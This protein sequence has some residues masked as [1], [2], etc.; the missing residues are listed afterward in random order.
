[1]DIFVPGRICLFGEH[2]DWAG[3][4]RRLNSAIARGVCL[5]TGTNQGLYAEVAPHPTHLVV[6]ADLGGPERVG[7]RELPME[8]VALRAEAEGGGPFAY[9]AGVAYQLLTHYRVGGLVLDNTRTDLPVKKG[10]ASSAAACVLAARAFNRVYNLKLTVRGE[11]EAAYRGELMTPSRCGRMDQGC[12]YGRRPVR[13]T[14][15]ADLVEVSPVSVGGDISMLIV[16]LQA[17]KDTLRILH[18]LNR[19]YPFA[20]GDRERHVHEYLGDINRRLVDRAAAAI[21]AGD[22]PAVGRLM[23]EAQALFDRY[24]TPLCPEELEAPKLH[25]VLDYGPIQELI[26]GG[27]GVGS[28]GDGAAQLVARSPKAR[29]EAAQILERDLGVRCLPLDLARPNRIRKAVVPAA[30]FG[31][32]MFPASK[33]VKKELAP[34]VDRDGLAKPIVQVIIEEALAA[35]IEEI[36]LIIRPEDRDILERY[37]RMPIAPAHYNSLPTALQAY[38]DSLRDIGGRVIFIPQYRREG[39]GHAVLCA[40]DWVGEEPFLLMLGDH[41][42]RSDTE[43]VCAAQV[44][45]AYQETSVTVVGLAPTLEEEVPSF[46]TVTGRWEN[47]GH[48]LTVTELAEKPTVEYARAKLRVEG[49]EDYLTFFGLYALEPSIFTHLQYLCDHRRRQG[50]QVQLTDAL[51]LLR[52]ATG[53]AGVL[54]RGRRFDTGRPSAYV[55]TLLAFAEAAP[56]PSEAAR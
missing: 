36:A 42:Y 43:D 40:R 50:E 44:L 7:P 47:P 54:V 5:I 21:E 37:F 17:G 34:I 56:A 16:D 29:D 9:I 22:A 10:L 11:M 20:T 15:D 52:R 4:Y 8:A 23:A 14:F 27:K 53:L 2:S 19:C 38:A 46:G 24:L 33:A 32:R 55:R 31:N 26:W 41:V 45:A 25:E 39:F 30:G 35:G 51:E 18:D 1:M 3:A 28:G 6:T 48:L 12:A 49:L 13:M